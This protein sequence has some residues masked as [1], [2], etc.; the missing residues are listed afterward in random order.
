MC[1]DVFKTGLETG[2]LKGKGQKLV[3]CFGNGVEAGACD[4]VCL[5]YLV[6]E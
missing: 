5:L 6:I 4:W 2:K 3:M 1:C